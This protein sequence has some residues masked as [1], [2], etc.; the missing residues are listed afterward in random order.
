MKNRRHYSAYPP[1]APYF[2]RE[3]KFFVLEWRLFLVPRNVLAGV[4]RS[5]RGSI[6]DRRSGAWERQG[7]GRGSLRLRRQF[8]N[9]Q[10]F[11]K[12]RVLRRAALNLA[13]RMQNRRVIPTVENPTN[14]EP[15]GGATPDR[16]QIGTKTG[17]TFP[18]FCFVGDWRRFRSRFARGAVE[19]E[20]ARRLNN[21]RNVLRRSA[22]VYAMAQ[23]E[24]VT[25]GGTMLF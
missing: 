17:L 8:Q 13:A 24:N 16:H 20:V 1:F 18:R 23:I 21:R 19:R 9:V 12:L 14:L 15:V 11:R 5:G 3:R 7:A 6:P 25:G 4:D 22:T 10:L 2:A